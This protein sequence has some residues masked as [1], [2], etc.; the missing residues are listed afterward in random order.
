MSS[1]VVPGA[2]ERDDPVAVEEAFILTKAFTIEPMLTRSR[3]YQRIL[4]NYG[5]LTSRNVRFIRAP[6]R[7]RVL[8]TACA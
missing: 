4:T 2:L 6:V 7:R 3:R 5:Q 1:H 8:G